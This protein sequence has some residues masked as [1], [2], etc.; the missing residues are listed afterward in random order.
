MRYGFLFGAGAEIAYNL[1]SG[2]RFALEIFRQDT[3][4]SKDFFKEMREK[5]DATTPYANQW[6]PKDYLNKNIS[7]FG[8]A[9]FQNIIMST[10]EHKR[11]QIVEKVNEFDDVAQEINKRLKASGIDVDGA[12]F[13]L[14]NREVNNIQLGQVIAYNE[15]LKTGNRLFESTYFSGLLTVYRD[16]MND[17]NR[18]VLGKII[19]SIMQ[20]Q[21]GALS[22]DLSRNIN[23]NLFSK[24]D[25]RIDLFDDFG[26]LI[27]L[28]YSAAGV[29]GLEYLLE[30][31]ES[32]TSTPYGIIL[33]FAQ[34]LIEEI[35]ASVLDYKA[36]I[37]SNW[38][39]LYNPSSDWGKFCKISIFL[40]SVREYMLKLGQEA[41]T[42]NS[43]GYYNTLK[44]SLDNV[45][46]EASIIATTNYNRIIEEVLG[47]EHPVTYLN[48]SVAVWYDPYLNKIGSAEDLDNSEH[49]IIIPL[50]F[51]QSG[52]KP[53]TSISMSVKYVEMYNQ[54][55][56]S[57]AVVVVGFGFGTDDEHINGILRTLVDDDKK[58]LIVVRLNHGK[59]EVDESKHIA[60]KLKIRSS[61][62]IHTILV[63]QDGTQNGKTWTSCL[64][65]M[66]DKE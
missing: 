38:H 51:T 15:A 31:K 26:D 3:S 30:E 57:D 11:K 61:S 2:G 23:D 39:Y 47:P 36:L 63:N 13:A 33:R 7:T 21:L 35:Y 19:L 45:D 52:T 55:K 10:V 60:K 42:E 59:S 14:L 40:L 66:I 41:V 64:Q 49:H 8:R 46:F 27:R 17:P 6:L 12:F 28:N 18:V 56:Q 44:A 54:W 37:D 9:V 20:L 16:I 5:V 43:N 4:S 62:R 53:M 29:S 24:K 25:E 50:I 34:L 58:D 48:G 22:E 32:E 1:P 65:M